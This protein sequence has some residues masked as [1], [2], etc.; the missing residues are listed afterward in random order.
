MLRASFV[1]LLLAYK[2]HCIVNNV[3]PTYEDY[4]T[5]RDNPRC[6]YDVA[7]DQNATTIIISYGYGV[8]SHKIVTSDGY[9]ITLFRIINYSVSVERKVPVL[10]Q[11][12]LLYSGASF[13]GKGQNSLGFILADAGYD[14]WLGNM[15]GTQ[16]SEEHVTLSRDDIKFW[17]FD[18]DDISFYDVTAQLQYIT[19]VNPENG[20]IIYVG[21]SIGATIALAYGATFPQEAQNMVKL[22][23]FLAPNAGTKNTKSL[24]LRILLLVTES[25]VKV[26][27]NTEVAKYLSNGS[28]LDQVLRGICLNDPILMKTC[29]TFLNS[30]ILGPQRE[31]DASAVPVFFNHVPSG[32]GWRVVKQIT[33]A[34]AIGLRAYDFG[35]YNL[36]QY[37]TLLPPLYDISKIEVPIYI[38]H[39]RGDWC[40]T[41]KDSELLYNRL[42]HRAKIFGKLEITEKDFNH[43]DFIYGRNVKKI[44]YDK[45]LYL[46]NSLRY[47]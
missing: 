30:I 36:P 10:L 6:W 38:V 19:Q 17:N 24:L 46:I 37:G 11:H 47:N 1:L 21:H 44:L 42:S 15:R 13:V 26:F 20:K 33:D 14:V 31:T 28:V 12:G 18:V 40:I 5:I 4:F 39:S 45:L 23:I 32:T 35:I 29:V 43:N 2:S 3:C 16:Y 8:E 41:P 27:I 9:I 7:A 22:F 25:I 34:T